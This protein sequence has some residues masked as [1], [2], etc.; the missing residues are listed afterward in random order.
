MGK[1][2]VDIL[3]VVFDY[4]EDYVANKDGNNK[5]G[6]DDNT[7]TK[8][9]Y[10]TILAFDSSICNVLDDSNDDDFWRSTENRGRLYI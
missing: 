4:I 10:W 2:E 1:D 5:D 6:N 9:D 3:E 8:E 7:E